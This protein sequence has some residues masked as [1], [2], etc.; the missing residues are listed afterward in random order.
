MQFWLTD[1]H[2]R[3]LEENETAGIVMEASSTISEILLWPLYST[4]GTCVLNWYFFYLGICTVQTCNKK[5]LQVQI[6]CLCVCMCVCVCVYN[7][8]KF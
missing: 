4:L 5:C 7:E 2:Q 6:L 8:F 1:V 3:E